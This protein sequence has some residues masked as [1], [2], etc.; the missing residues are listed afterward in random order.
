MKK[1]FVILIVLS[2]TVTAFAQTADQEPKF[3]FGV[4]VA[5]G[6]SWLRSDKNSDQ[7]TPESDGSL[8]RVSYGFITDFRISSNYT[9]STGVDVNYEGGK[10]KKAITSGNT[11]TLWDEKVKL[12]YIEIP[13]TIRMNTNRIGYIKYYFQAGLAPGINIR[14]RYDATV[15]TQS[16][17][18]ESTDD[19]TDEDVMKDINTFNISM[20]VGGGINYNLS[21][22]TDLLVGL[23]FHNGFLDIS[24]RNASNAVLSNSKLN[25]NLLSLNLGILF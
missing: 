15:T 17:G 8:L 6:I 16:P 19:Y 14:S 3:H 2:H 11:T 22:T 13:L 21:G 23:T 12:R 1:L 9:F 20:V 10:L 18:K 4:K 25:S 5:P 24:D 7:N